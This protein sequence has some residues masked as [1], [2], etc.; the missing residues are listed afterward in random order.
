MPDIPTM[1]NESN[2]GTAPEVNWTPNMSYSQSFRTDR[3]DPTCGGLV[4]ELVLTGFDSKLANALKAVPRSEEIQVQTLLRGMGSEDFQTRELAESEA[5]KLGYKAVRFLQNGL[6]ASDDPEVR[7][8]AQ[9]CIN[10]I[11]SAHIKTCLEK[12]DPIMVGSASNDIAPL[13]QSERKEFERRIGLAD[14]FD[15]PTEELQAAYDFYKHPGADSE[16]ANQRELEKESLLLVKDAPVSLRLEYAKLLSDV[17]GDA[18]PS[19]DDSTQAKDLLEQVADRDEAK[20]YS[21]QIAEIVN[22]LGGF[23]A[24]PDSLKKKLEPVF[25]KPRPFTPRSEKE[26]EIL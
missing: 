1:R 26:S 11:K 15:V 18:E 16:L 25:E 14:K 20:R 3:C 24:L 13:G 21:D 6:V 4:P 8:R 7:N 5:K 10:S 23:E 19:A 17:N 2:P 9:R 22:N 12:V